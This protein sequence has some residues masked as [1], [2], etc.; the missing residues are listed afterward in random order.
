[1]HCPRR[2]FA[3]RLTNLSA[4][5]SRLTNRLQEVLVDVALRVGGEAGKRLLAG[6]GISSSGDR[7]LS[8]LHD[9]EVPPTPKASVV[10][11][12]DFALKK[13]RTY[14]TIIVDQETRRPLEVL[15]DRTA[16]TLA[17]WL[18]AH[19]EIGVVTRDR[20]SEY[21]RGVSLGAPQATQVLDRWHLLKNLREAC[22]RQLR[23]FQQAIDA[24]ATEVGADYLRVPRSTREETA[25]EEALRQRRDRIQEVREL[26]AQ[27]VSIS[28]I[29]RQL[30]ASRSFVRR[31]I[32]LDALPERRP[33]KQQASLLDPFKTHLEKRW[34]EGCRNAKQLWREVR[35]RG[36]PGGYKRVHQWRQRQRLLDARAAQGEPAVL[37]AYSVSSY[38]KGFSSRQLVWLLVHDTERL[39]AEEQEVLSRLCKQEPLIEQIRNLAQG[40]RA[41]FKNKRP[42]ALNAWFQGVAETALED[43]KTFAVSLKR[44]QDGLIAAIALPWSNGR[45]EGTVTK[46]KLIKR[47]MF[48]R[49]SFDLL[50]KR[51]L[52]AG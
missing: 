12:D 32:K 43:L 50:R 5:Y 16:E 17:A 35:E 23:C 25:R 48:G 27:G 6:L 39:S 33:R 18:E 49:G 2:I 22:E 14:G 19:P 38:R 30:K 52:L 15:G 26:H 3:E 31:S 13:G 29:S 10:G 21:E 7:L 46:V 9:K 20:A 34:R 11:V 4:P 28:V 47:S 8:L 45:L 42:E 40:F 36:Y 37:A 51:I 24:V 44:E 1:M 41:L